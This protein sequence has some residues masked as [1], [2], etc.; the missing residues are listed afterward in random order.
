[1]DL[2]GF[3]V[4]D[5]GVLGILLLGALFGFVTGFVRGGLFV[6]SWIGAIV[7]TIYAFPLARPLA[8]NH[9]AP[10]WLA[11]LIGGAALFIIA[12]I[13]LYLVSH[14]L[15]GWV[16][17]SRLNALD[18]SLGLIAGVVTAALVMSVGYLLLSD[19]VA[20]DPPE[21]LKTARTRPAVESGALLVRDL[22]PGEFMSS[23][24][25]ALRRSRDQIDTIEETREALER[26]TTPPKTS[27][28]TERPGY[29]DEPREQL[30]KLI[31]ENQ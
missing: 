1:M 11:D 3:N 28:P 4:F 29:K 26:L 22:L 15:S 5:L 27:A 18:R 30:D 19:T 10:E 7:A 12:L 9:I 6:A 17:S 2:F 14:M 25:E 31:Q 21:W 13:I 24:G 23:T 20:E 8:R 16:R